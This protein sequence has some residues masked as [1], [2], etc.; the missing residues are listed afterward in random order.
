MA[1]I[2]QWV[3]ESGTVPPLRNAVSKLI[4]GNTFLKTALWIT[5]SAIFGHTVEIAE[6]IRFGCLPV[7][8]LWG[9]PD[10][11]ASLTG[12]NYWHYLY[13]VCF[14]KL[15]S[16]DVCFDEQC[17]LVVNKMP[18]L[19]PLRLDEVIPVIRRGKLRDHGN[20][21]CDMRLLRYRS[22]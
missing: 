2:I 8:P 13:T 21:F 4:L 15:T 17:R 19:F 16:R 1:F 6:Q 18:F 7:R 22:Q 20:L 12:D 5:I 9:A 11:F 10:Q 14:G 3:S